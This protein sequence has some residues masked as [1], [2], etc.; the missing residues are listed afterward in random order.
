MEMWYSACITNVLE[1]KLSLTYELFSSLVPS[2]PFLPFA[3][4]LVTSHFGW[5]WYS[6]GKESKIG[7]SYV[8]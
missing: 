7:K 6:L 4:A 8:S 2:H 3:R 5:Y 1:L